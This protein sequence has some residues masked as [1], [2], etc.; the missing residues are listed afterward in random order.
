MDIGGRKMA[1]F[2]HGIIDSFQYIGGSL[3]GIILGALVDRSWSYYFYFMV[4]FGLIGGTLMSTIRNRAS[5][6]KE[7]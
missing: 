7:G 6:K 4:P 1:G 5:L 2:A 3:A